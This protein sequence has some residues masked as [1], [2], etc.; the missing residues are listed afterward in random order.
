MTTQPC[1][2]GANKLTTFYQLSVNSRLAQTIAGSKEA[3][4]DSVILHFNNSVQNLPNF[5]SQYSASQPK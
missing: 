2:G 1:D 3:S 5:V 4:V